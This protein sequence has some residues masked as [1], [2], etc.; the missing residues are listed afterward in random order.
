[1]AKLSI[2]FLWSLCIILLPV[3]AND[4]REVNLMTQS[5]KEKSCENAF[6][7]NQIQF[8]SFSAE[9]HRQFAKEHFLSLGC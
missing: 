4:T 2:D 9:T 8:H 7:N 6:C 5:L 3:S 1:M